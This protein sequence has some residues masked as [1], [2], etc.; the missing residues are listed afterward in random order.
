[1]IAWGIVPG[2]YE[3]APLALRASAGFM[4]WADFMVL[5]LLLSERRLPG[6]LQ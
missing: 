6:L 3:D 5:V 1:M 2:W 4:E